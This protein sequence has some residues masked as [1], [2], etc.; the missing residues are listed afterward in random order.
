MPLFRK[1]AVTE[2]KEQTALLKAVNG[3]LIRYASRLREDGEEILGKD[4]RIVVT[5][6]EV[7]VRFGATDVFLCPRE[8]VRAWELMSADGIR[9]EKPLAD[10]GTESVTA[11]W[12]YYHK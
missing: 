9:L 7:A 10:G 1:K 11:Y 4:G 3:R 6:Q 5:E 12:K 2:S 8:S